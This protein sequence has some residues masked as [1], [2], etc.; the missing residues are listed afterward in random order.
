MNYKG[1]ASQDERCCQLC[2]GDGIGVGIVWEKLFWVK[3]WAKIQRPEQILHFVG[4]RG[5]CTQSTVDGAACA[6]LHH[7]RIYIIYPLINRRVEVKFNSRMGPDQIRINSHFKKVRSDEKHC[8]NLCEL[9]NRWKMWSNF[10][11]KNHSGIMWKRYWRWKN[12]SRETS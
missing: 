2:D 8:K 11:K 6:I 4:V 10:K 5:Q 1:K 7:V 9:Y 3:S 12:G